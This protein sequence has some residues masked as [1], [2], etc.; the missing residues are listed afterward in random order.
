MKIFT[1]LF[2]GIICA[3]SLAENKNKRSPQNEGA[4][5]KTLESTPSH[6]LETATLA[7]GCFWCVESDLEKIS[8]VTQVISGYAGGDEKNPTYKEV[9]SGSTGHVEAV[10][11]YFD[12]RKISYS[13]IL[14]VFWR[15]INPLDAGGQFVDRG[16]QY[17]SAIFYHTP[18]Q[19][20]LAEQ[21]K[22]ELQDKGPFKQDIATP[23][24]AFKSFYEAEEY[25]QDYYKK[26]PLKYK[27]YRWRSGRD[28]FLE[29]TWEKFKDFRTPHK[30]TTKETKTSSDTQTQT[31]SDTNTKTDPDT[32]TQTHSDTNT[33]TDPD[34]QTQTRSDTNTKT[35]PDTQTQTRSDTNTKTDPDTQTQT[36]SDT[37]TK[38]DPDTQTQTRSD[39]NTKTDPDT[40]SKTSAKPTITFEAKIKKNYS[41]PSAE[42]LKKKLSSIQYKVTQRDKTEPPFKNEYWDN[43]A[44]GIYVDIVSGE[45][46]FS[47][48]DK[49]DS[50]T[51][52]PSFTKPLA[53]ENIV[54]KL[55]T[56]L[57]MKRTEV[58][59]RSADSHLGHVF[60]DG[61]APTGL[62]Y[63][64]NSASLRFVPKHKLKA[65][66]YE[67][68][69]SLFKKERA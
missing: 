1:Y 17:S 66:G 9:S 62:R 50:K 23:I 44:E 53:P 22:K 68:F 69:Q 20:K 5:M 52:W 7:G 34:T 18:E 6:T 37:N 63:C 58:R 21:S 15:K 11:V 31:R 30:N 42:E 28:Q 46:L 10:Q 55:D 16:F 38:T 24:Q 2:I 25:H 8:G 64:I 29:E 51:G 40:Q 41:K 35:D 47:S 14:D 45:P 13:Q 32:Q 57:W 3:G 39:T 36:R 26:S 12:P 43:K 19:K 4:D 56:K 60:E 49:Y 59:S 54:T 27:F 33:K 65:E 61:P 48:L 67:E